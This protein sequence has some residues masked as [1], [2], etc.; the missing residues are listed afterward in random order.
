MGLRRVPAVLFAVGTLAGTSGTALGAK[1][2][3]DQREAR[4]REDVA[5]QEYLARKALSDRR[6]AATDE[7]LAAFARLQRQSYTDVVHRMVEFLHRHDRQVRRIE[8]LLVDGIELSV[9][10]T[11][12]P[13][14]H[15]VD[16]GDWVTAAI[17]TVAASSG[18]ANVISKAADKYGTASTGTALS[19]L[20][21]AAKEKA[22]R[23]FFGGGSRASGGGGMALGRKAYEV[24]IAGTGLLVAGAHAKVL[25]VKALAHARQYE[26]ARAIEC[27][28]LD[29]A[30]THLRAVNQRAAEM[31]DVLTELRAQAVSALDELESV[32]FEAQQ[33][34]A[35]FQKAM[36]LVKA[37][38]DVA[39]TRLISPDGD[40]TDESEALTVKYRRMTA[41]ED[42]G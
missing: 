20:H 15:E 21:G 12:T 26:A 35:L 41:K 42:D 32:T 34:A 3:L 19:Q 38:Q 25:G 10:S 17:R 24:A 23:A 30:D 7:R 6:K 11:P 39:A 27:A 8:R 22:T 9:T 1:G 18:T 31:Y 40:L 37:V 13:T 14:E 29:L 5:E 16:A 2:A 4:K 33:H 28:N 36:T